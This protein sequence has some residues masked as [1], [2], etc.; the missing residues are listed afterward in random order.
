MLSQQQDQ[1]GGLTNSLDEILGVQRDQGNTISNLR[2]EILEI[3]QKGLLRII[4]LKLR[5]RL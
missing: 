5:S 2:Q 4:W 1:N 3:R